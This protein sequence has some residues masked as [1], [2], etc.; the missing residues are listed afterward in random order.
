MNEWHGL[1]ITAGL[2]DRLG[3]SGSLAWTSRA[4]TSICKALAVRLFGVC[5]DACGR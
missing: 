4:D 5:P 2:L 3:A 1:T